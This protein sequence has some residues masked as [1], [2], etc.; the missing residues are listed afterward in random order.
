MLQD[1]KSDVTS[2]SEQDTKSEV[3]KSDVTRH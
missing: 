1:T 2:K 3:T